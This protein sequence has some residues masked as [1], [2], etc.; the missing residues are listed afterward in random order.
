MPLFILLLISSI[1]F[2][3]IIFYIN[4]MVCI[5]TL[6]T[7]IWHK[8]TSDFLMSPWT[9]NLLALRHTCV[10]LST[11]AAFWHLPFTYNRVCLFTT[12]HRIHTHIN[13]WLLSHSNTKLESLYPWKFWFSFLSLWRIIAIYIF[14]NSV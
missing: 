5:R 10:I 13:P 7:H 6:K 8:R 2:K 1:N 12:K 9:C 14:H 3:G 4:A 11:G